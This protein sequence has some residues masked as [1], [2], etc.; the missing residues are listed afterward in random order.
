MDDWR[1]AVSDYQNGVQS[2]AQSNLQS[3]E[4]LLQS[5]AGLITGQESILEGMTGEKFSDRLK[6]E[7]SKFQED[8][9]LDFS[10]QALA[11]TLLKGAAKLASWRANALNRSW[12]TTQASRFNEQENAENISGDAGTADA[13]SVSASE[14]PTQ[15]PGF[16]SVDETDP[17]QPGMGTRIPISSTRGG[18]RVRLAPTE[19]EPVTQDADDGAVPTLTDASDTPFTDSLPSFAR[20]VGRGG[21]ALRQYARGGLQ[22]GTSD[23]I[24]D[25]IN[26]ATGKDAP[27]APTTLSQ[28]E[29]GDD[30]AAGTGLKLSTEVSDDIQGD[31]YKAS[32]Q[33]SEDASGL[34]GGAEEAA[35]GAEAE[36]GGLVEDLAPEI[37]AASSA[38]SSIAG[39]LG[40]AIPIVGAGLGLYSAISSGMDL[41]KTI[42]D[43][44]T[45]PYAGIRGQLASAQS[46]ITGL[47]SDVS[48]DEFASKIGA[49]QP[50][51]GSLAARPNMDTAMGGGIALHI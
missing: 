25:A 16:G 42:K 4:S 24:G 14:P 5:K 33:A 29:I 21:A 34:T 46:R 17:F 47:Q 2:I 28:T 11:P 18:G 13:P 36:A 23:N 20:G 39:V 19:E 37:T 49:R 1:R 51:F 9:G 10:A 3:K 44:N 38:F 43:E 45:D 48:A 31:V 22:G 8:L 27:R 26:D 6:E 7:A 40:D 32:Q 35:S 12:K 15:T 41:A 50:Q 30:P